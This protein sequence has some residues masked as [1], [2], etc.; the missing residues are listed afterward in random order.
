[1]IGVLYDGYIYR[2]PFAP[3]AVFAELGYPAPTLQ[4]VQ[5]GIQGCVWRRAEACRG[6][7]SCMTAVDGILMVHPSLLADISSCCPR[8]GSLPQRGQPRLVPST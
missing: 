2:R 3:P 1:M 7:R 4:P 5:V 8:W 6:R